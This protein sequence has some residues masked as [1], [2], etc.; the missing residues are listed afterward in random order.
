MKSRSKQLLSAA[1]SRA[2]TLASWVKSKAARAAT[3]SKPSLRTIGNTPAPSSS[4]LAEI[5]A[6]RPLIHAEID[7]AARKGHVPDG[8]V[9]SL[10]VNHDAELVERQ[11]MLIEE[12]HRLRASLSRLDAICPPPTPPVAEPPKP[13]RRRQFHRLDKLLGSGGAGLVN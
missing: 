1:A 10:L 11:R 3:G 5:L 12:E 7:G 6:A 8:L 2:R 13:P 9:I 4:L